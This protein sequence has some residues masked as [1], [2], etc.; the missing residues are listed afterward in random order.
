M[1]TSTAADAPAWTLDDRHPTAAFWR[2]RQVHETV[3]HLWDADNALGQPRPIDPLLAWDGVLEVRDVIYP[4][5]VRLGRVQPMPRSVHLV[6][7]DVR[8]DAV[9]GEGESIELHGATEVLLRLLWHRADLNAHVPDAQTRT[10]LSG[11]ITP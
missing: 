5:Q 3:M 1:L 11:A 2:R 8:G 6:A 9:L 7:T 4:R 10:L